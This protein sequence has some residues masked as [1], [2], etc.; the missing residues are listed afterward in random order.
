VHTQRSLKVHYLCHPPG[1]LLNFVYAAELPANYY[2][3]GIFCIESKNRSGG[4]EGSYDFAAILGEQSINATL[5][6]VVGRTFS[7]FIA[8]LAQRFLFKAVSLDRTARYVGWER[9]RFSDLPLFRVQPVSDKRL[10]EAC[11]RH[12]FYFVGSG[13]ELLMETNDSQILV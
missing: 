3:P 4:L 12:D 9:N 7:V 6:R 2:A 11:Q 10:E 13:A 1:D 8:V 5:E